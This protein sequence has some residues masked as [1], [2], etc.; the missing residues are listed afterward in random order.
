MNKNKALSGKADDGRP[1][2]LVVMQAANE[3]SQL[4]GYPVD[5]VGAIA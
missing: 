1:D 4:Q 2:H 3:S 5:S